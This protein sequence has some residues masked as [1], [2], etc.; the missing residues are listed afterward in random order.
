MFRT[1]THRERE[2]HGWGNPVRGI[3]DVLIQSSERHCSQGSKGKEGSRKEVRD[4]CLSPKCQLQSKKQRQKNEQILRLQTARIMH[5]RDSCRMGSN[6]CVVAKTAFVAWAQS[7]GLGIVQHQAIKILFTR[8]VCTG[9]PAWSL[10]LRDC[11]WLVNLSF[12][13]LDLLLIWFDCCSSVFCL[14]C[15]QLAYLD[16]SWYFYVHT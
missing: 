10:R 9:A 13:S 3:S 6:K 5:R 11:L 15:T 16:G 2:R 7:T 8:S 1:Y 4:E 14:V 12:F